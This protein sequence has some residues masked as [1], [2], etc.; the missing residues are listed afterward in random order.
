MKVKISIISVL[1]AL[2]VLFT[3]YMFYNSTKNKKENTISVKRAFDKSKE[4]VVLNDF[5]IIKNAIALYE[6]TKG[7]LPQSLNELAPEYIK[8][9]PSDPWGR[10]Y[11]YERNGNS[12]TLISSGKDGIFGTSDD[13][14]RVF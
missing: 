3:I 9:L 13:I 5:E 1:I 11:R 8:V 7:E 10:P 6:S 4:T 14:K 2:L 12:F